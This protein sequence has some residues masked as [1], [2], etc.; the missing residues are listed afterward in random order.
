M[1]SRIPQPNFIGPTPAEVVDSAA[2]TGAEWGQIVS[3]GIQAGARLYQEK[4]QHDDA[5]E[6]LRIQLL[7]NDLGGK[8]N[9]A[10][11][12]EEQAKVFQD[13]KSQ[14]M[15]IYTSLA[16]GNKDLANSMYEGTAQSFLAKMTPTDLARRG[17]FNFS[18]DNGQSAPQASVQ[19]VSQ[20]PG[21]SLNPNG[22][23]S[24]SAIAQ[25]PTQ[26][27]AQPQAA[28]QPGAPLA[29]PLPESIKELTPDMIGTLSQNSD[30]TSAF[31]ADMKA[32]YPGVSAKGN[33]TL[34]A[35]LIKNN[36]QAFVD[37]ISKNQD[38]VGA[39][40]NGQSGQLA[41]TNAQNQTETKQS[42][43]TTMT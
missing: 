27:N 43:I 29:H 24:S 15:E 17:A 38:K 41:Q 4:K 23:P 20:A 28:L 21:A 37:F 32:K 11:T 36:P 25:V 7:T 39:L 22:T 2:K 3:Q 13:N 19:N 5:S 26:Q 34:D 6:Q 40:V 42:T 35:A 10:Q 33:P 18:Q 12:P 8:L 9:A 14:A 31:R 30:L 16:K 1:L